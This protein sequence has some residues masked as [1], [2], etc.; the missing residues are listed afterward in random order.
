MCRE[1]CK[2]VVI[3]LLFAYRRWRIGNGNCAAV[4]YEWRTAKSV[5]PLYAA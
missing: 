4:A 5:V 3:S 1:T 2:L